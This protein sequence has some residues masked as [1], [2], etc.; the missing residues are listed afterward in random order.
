MKIAVLCATYKSAQRKSTHC[1]L[2]N[3]VAY[4]RLH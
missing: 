2:R 4:S 3:T 1:N